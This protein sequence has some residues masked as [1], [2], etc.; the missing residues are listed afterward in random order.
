[1]TVLSSQLNRH[2]NERPTHPVDPSRAPKRYRLRR[3]RSS[4]PGASYDRIV[5]IPDAETPDVASG[6]VLKTDTNKP[7]PE[8]KL[9]RAYLFSAYRF[10]T[11]ISIG[12][13]VSLL[14]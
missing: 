14:S 4:T 1:M 2:P 8:K 12:M 10:Q 5:R 9:P 6:S 7:T 3:I 13:T 11:R